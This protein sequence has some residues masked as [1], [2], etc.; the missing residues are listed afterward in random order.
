MEKLLI[1]GGKP[2]KGEV[3]ISGAKNSVLPILAASLLSDEEVV[4]G[5]V[6]H[7]AGRNYNHI[8]SNRNGCHFN[9]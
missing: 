1:K 5:N 4:I 2:L 3:R 8:S 9:N 7:L 6:P